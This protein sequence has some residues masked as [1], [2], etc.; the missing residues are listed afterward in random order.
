MPRLLILLFCFIAIVAKGQPQLELNAG[1][2]E[3][4]EVSI[5]STPNE[6]LIE[7]SKSW[8]NQF[9]RTQKGADISDVTANSMTISAYKRNAFFIRNNGD[10]FQYAIRYT[11]KL[12]FSGSS[13]T[14]QFIVNDIFTDQDILVEYKLPNYYNSDGELKD[15]YSTIKPSLER[16]VNDIVGSHYNFLINFR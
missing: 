7:T 4:V 2:F 10:T 15:G 1:R 16:T 9:N 8:A 12:K 6:K 5:P 11:M 3:P 13:Y 14:L